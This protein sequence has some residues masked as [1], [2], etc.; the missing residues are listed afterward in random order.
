MCELVNN[1]SMVKNSLK[2]YMKG[3]CV[4]YKYDKLSH[5]NIFHYI[6]IRFLIVNEN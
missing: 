4:P 2:G 5:S 3:L 1:K 6:I